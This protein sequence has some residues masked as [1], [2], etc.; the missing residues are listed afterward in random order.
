MPTEILW[1]LL[2]GRAAERLGE[3]ERALRAFGWVAG[4]WRNADPGLQP[5]AA[6]AREALARLSGKPSVGI[7]G[8]SGG[9]VAFPLLH[10]AASLALMQ[11]PALPQASIAGTVR[12][13]G[14]ECADSRARRSC[15]SDLS[16]AATG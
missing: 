2:R 13:G 6:E 4:M 10:I 8:H 1:S 5:Y 15:S 11:G 3:R 12:D 14:D 9:R 16:R 7:V